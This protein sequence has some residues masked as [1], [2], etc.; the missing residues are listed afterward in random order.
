MFM[1]K[2]LLAIDVENIDIPAIEFACYVATLSRSKLTG[3]FIGNE[4]GKT[5]AKN[6]AYDL[7]SADGAVVRSQRVAITK[8]SLDENIRLFEELCANR[9]VRSELMHMDCRQAAGEMIAESRFA[10]LI[11]LK[12]NFCFNKR[13]AASPSQFVAELLAAAECPVLVAPPAFN[14][15]DEIIFAYDGSQSSV[16]AIK[17]FTYL[18][19]RLSDQRAML[20]E[21]TGQANDGLTAKEKIIEL[22]KVHY[23]GIG[24]HTLHGEAADE[25]FMYLLQ[26]KTSMVVMGAY[27]KNLFSKVLKQSTAHQLLKAIDCPFFITHC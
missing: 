11:I 8:P 2:I 20:L 12:A 25:L 5:L 7:S 3:V 22:L 9:S 15:I 17:Q 6:G 21:V 19:P 16:F 13:P 4:P 18:F 24:F 14:G 26:K 10:D 1:E 23:S 27:G